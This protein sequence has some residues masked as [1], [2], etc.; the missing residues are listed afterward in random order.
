MSGSPAIAL[1]PV[2]D[3]DLPV[4]FE[5][6]QDPVVV[7]MAAFTAADPADRVAFS[8]HWA[9]IRSDAQI[10]IRTVLVDGE[11]AGHVASFVQFGEREVTYWLGRR[12]WG[13]GIATRALSAFLR[14]E[15]TRPLH[16]RAARDNIASIRVLEKCGFR[17]TGYETSFANARGAET[18]EAIL[19]LRAAES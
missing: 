2:I 14:E 11:A 18:E 13:R 3:S 4:F 12:Y 6:Q 9:K 5:H 15:T 1:R 16:A 19:E 10:M 8:A 17:V 7:Q